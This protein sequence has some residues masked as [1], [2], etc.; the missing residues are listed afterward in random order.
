MGMT[1]RTT[2][3]DN[4]QYYVIPTNTVK[5]P[6]TFTPTSGSGY[7]YNTI[8]FDAPFSW[9][10]TSSLV[11]EICYNN[12]TVDSSGT[13]DK[14]VGYADGSTSTQGNLFWQTNIDCSGSFTGGSDFSYFSSGQKPV[15]TFNITSSITAIPA[16]DLNSA[17]TEYLTSN[18][19]LYYFTNNQIL[20]RIRSL[21]ALNYGCTQVTID[22]AGTGA[23]PFLNNN[24]SNYLMNK[25]YRVLPG[26]NYSNGSY[27]ITFYFSRAEKQGWENATGQSFSNIKVIKVPG[28]ISSVTPATPDAAGTVQVVTPTNVGSV[29]T[30]YFIT[31]TFT[32]GF[33][34]FGFGIPGATLPITLINFSGKL[35][36]DNSLLSWSTSSEQNTH[37]FDVE[38]SSDGVNY[39][40]IGEVKAVGYSNS[41][42]NYSLLDK[43]FALDKNYYRLKTV[44][45]DNK[46]KI[47]DVVILRNIKNLQSF[48]VVNN[49]FKDYIEVRLGKVPQGNVKLQLSDLSGKVLQTQT[50][51]GLSQNIL[52]LNTSSNLLSQGVYILSAEVDGTRYSVKVMRQ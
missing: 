47:G 40:K 36:G 51:S 19:D 38:K 21:S 46:T 48:V 32:N 4:G 8:P 45:N 24:P 9:D 31:A 42:S 28:Q 41:T 11:V 25:T 29:D 6:F 50:F 49:P 15:A 1:P 5:N 23:S 39:R 7:I 2:L 52:R 35:Q 33:S 37:H 34:G 30:L 10:G 22:R 18:N 27:E 26:S 3:V 20:A 43:E 12:G 13:V 17:R 44:D 14:T 16:T